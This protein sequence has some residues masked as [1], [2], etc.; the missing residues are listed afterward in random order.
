MRPNF[1]IDVVDVHL[2][3]MAVFQSS[4]KSTEWEEKSYV[5]LCS[6]LCNFLKVLCPL[7]M[8]FFSFSCT[9]G[10]P[11]SFCFRIIFVLRAFNK[12]WTFPK[13]AF[14]LN[15]F[16]FFFKEKAFWPMKS[17]MKH[18]KWNFNT[19][20]LPLCEARLKKN[21]NLTKKNWCLVYFLL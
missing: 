15:V 8:I 11:Q 19:M 14:A 3:S 7:Y 12:R 1:L 4:E 17:K 6:D 18:I 13:I 2:N 5:S 16:N 20:L 9:L 21:Y 10:R